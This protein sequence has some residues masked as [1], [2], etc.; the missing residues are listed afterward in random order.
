[1]Q[2]IIYLIFAVF[3]SVLQT[4]SG[5]TRLVIMPAMEINNNNGQFFMRIERP[6]S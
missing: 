1:M 2:L 4:R 5:M 3:Y 6:P